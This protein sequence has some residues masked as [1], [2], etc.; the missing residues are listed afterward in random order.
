MRTNQFISYRVADV[1]NVAEVALEAG[2]SPDIIFQH[3]RACL[4]VV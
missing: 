2:N 4:A 1:K 3:Y